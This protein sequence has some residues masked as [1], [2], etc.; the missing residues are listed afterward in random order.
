MPLRRI[1]A[2]I[3]AFP[4]SV[5]GAAGA[6]AQGLAVPIMLDCDESTAQ[7][8]C[9]ATSLVQ[10]LDPNG[11][12]F[13]AV[14]ASPGSDHAMV[15]QLKEGDVV[16]IIEFDGSWRGVRYGDGKLGWVHSNWLVDLAG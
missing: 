7:A 14:R 8:A 13:L 5:L 10:G 12:N 11:D 1:V 4:A 6:H 3:I 9:Y 2:F 15:D 16:E